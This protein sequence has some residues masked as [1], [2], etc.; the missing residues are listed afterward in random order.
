MVPRVPKTAWITGGSGVLGRAIA[1]RLAEDGWRVGLFARDRDRLK[2]AEATIADLGGE[3][4]GFPADVLD[5]R[6]LGR[7]FEQCREWSGRCDALIC[8]AG[9]LRSVGPIAQADPETGWLDLEVS[10]RGMFQA[11][12]MLLPMLR[13]SGAGSITALVGPGAQA[14]LAYAAGYAAGQAALVRLVECLAVEFQADGVPVYALNPGIVPSPL[15]RGLIDTAEGRRWLPRFNAAMAEG[16]EVTPRP[17]AEMVAWL[18][19]E[20]PRELSGRVVSALLP[21]DLLADR[22][23]RIVEGDLGRLRLT[24]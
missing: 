7:A 10:V 13:E 15:L 5:A 1:E 14:G 18:V 20:R 4:R 17:A 6:R 22:L 8:A 2:A 11:A 9:Q 23:G 3:A 19:S 12:S 21:P 24:N 16:K